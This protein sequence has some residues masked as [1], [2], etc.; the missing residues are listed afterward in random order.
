MCPIQPLPYGEGLHLVSGISSSRSLGD[1]AEIPALGTCVMSHCL[2]H[3]SFGYKCQKHSSNLLKHQGTV[4]IDKAAGSWHGCRCSDNVISIPF[5][6]LV[7]AFLWAGFILRWAHRKAPRS[8]GLVTAMR[9]PHIPSRFRKIEGVMLIGRF[10]SHNRQGTKTLGG[11]CSL[12]D[13]SL[14]LAVEWHQRLQAMR[15]KGKKAEQILGC[16]SQ[17]MGA[18]QAVT[19]SL[20]YSPASLQR[21]VVLC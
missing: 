9:V 19:G 15:T 2:S 3:S 7:S 10:R 5:T 12:A 6:H 8:S 16:G 17:N 21:K 13:P 4:L 14:E 11:T 20:C 1:M 18:R